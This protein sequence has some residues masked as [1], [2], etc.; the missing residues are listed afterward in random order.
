MED[1]YRSTD[2]PVVFYTPPMANSALV[3]TPDPHS[4]L[5]SHKHGLKIEL[6]QRGVF[7]PFPKLHGETLQSSC[8]GI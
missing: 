1:G 4:F 6:K 3:F 8:D 5:P 2:I 7:F